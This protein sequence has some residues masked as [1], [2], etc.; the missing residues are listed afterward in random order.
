MGF[1]FVDGQVWMVRRAQ[2]APALSSC[3][4]SGCKLKER[5]PACPVGEDLA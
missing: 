1:T 5:R 4:G 3:N 2:I